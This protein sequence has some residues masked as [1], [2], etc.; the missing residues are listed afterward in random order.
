MDDTRDPRTEP[1]LVPPGAFNRKL[2]VHENVVLA[3][4]PPYLTLARTL[5][6][7]HRR[8]CRLDWGG[9]WN[10]PQRRGGFSIAGPAIGAPNSVTMLESLIANGAKRVI[11]VGCC[12]SLQPELKVGELV[13]PTEAISEEGASRHYRPDLYP[14][15]ASEPLVETVENL[16]SQKKW[17]IRKGA[18]WTTD[19]PYRETCEK[20]KKYANDGVLAVEMEL[21]ALFTVARCREIELAGVIAVSDELAS[22]EWK[23]GFFEPVFLRAS[24]RAVRLAL[25]VFKKASH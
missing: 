18:V 7:A 23:Q 6:R 17:P 16:A 4:L 13:I 24:T 10:V 9:L 14:P 19:A 15:R 2:P 11:A 1:V 20:V 8:K 21:S 3:I 22:L 25:N 5:A 12:G